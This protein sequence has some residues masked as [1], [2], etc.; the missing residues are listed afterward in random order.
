MRRTPL[1]A[2]FSRCLYKLLLGERFTAADV[3][4]IDQ[5][6]VDGRIVPLLREGG[7]AALE[8][9]LGDELRFVGVGGGGGGGG[10]G[11]GAGDD[12]DDSDVGEEDGGDERELVPGGR[13]IRVTEANKE[14]Y[15][16]L[17]VEDYLVG[18]AREGIAALLKGAHD[19][20]PRRVLHAEGLRAIDLELLVGGLPCIDVDDWR[21]NTGGTLMSDGEHAQLRDWFW[22]SVDGMDL[23]RRAKLLAFACGTGRLPAAGFSA[24]S[25]KFTVAV[26]RSEEEAHLPSAHT[27]IN[28]LC[29]PAYASYETLD[30]Q[31]R[32]AI[33]WDGFGFL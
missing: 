32:I 5:G 19:V 22:R 33:E 4:R 31:L 11:D 16:S 20:L 27:C 24:L 29:L 18:A 15:A 12:D 28:Q 7:V 30:R 6:F 13:H 21:L 17:L 25:P 9:A 1:S 10:G 3:G 8:D 23:E 26:H 14:E 2:G